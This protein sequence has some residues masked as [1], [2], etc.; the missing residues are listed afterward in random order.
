MPARTNPTLIACG[1]FTIAGAALTTQFAR[2][3]TFARTGAG[4]INMTLGEAVD[5]NESF[6]VVQSETEDVV[7]FVA[8]TSDTVKVIRARTT[9]AAT[10]PTD[11]DFE[12]AIYRAAYGNK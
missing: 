2:N 7:A 3:C 12:V 9:T 1:R 5:Q 8:H 11:G 6:M 10:T 4:E